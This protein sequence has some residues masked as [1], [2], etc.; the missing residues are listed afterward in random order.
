LEKSIE[1][2]VHNLGNSTMISLDI[3]GNDLS[4]NDYFF[5]G[6][7]KNKQIEELNLSG[8][9]SLLNEGCGEFNKI[10]TFLKMIKLNST[11][12]KL[13]VSRLTIFNLIKKKKIILVSLS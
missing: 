7:I 3:S 8:I 4:N 9:S 13:N 11:L 12:K 2:F 6:M 1:E 5:R 10:P